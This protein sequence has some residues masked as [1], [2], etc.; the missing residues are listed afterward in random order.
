[1]TSGDV[2]VVMLLILSILCFV[3][4]Q[5]MI[6]IAQSKRK[7]TCKDCDKHHKCDDGCCGGSSTDYIVMTGLM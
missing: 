6:D 1:M 2:A 7:D 3:A 4:L 5:Y